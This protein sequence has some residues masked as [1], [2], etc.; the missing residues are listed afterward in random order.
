MATKKQPKGTGFSYPISGEALPKGT[1][2]K[3]N[4]DGTI[5]FVPPKKDKKKGK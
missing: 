5:S 4:P 3:K 1:T 2:I